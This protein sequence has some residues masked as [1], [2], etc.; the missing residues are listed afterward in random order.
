MP[1]GISPFDGAPPMRRLKLTTQLT[2][3]TGAKL[4]SGHFNGT[5]APTSY[6]A[7]AELI[8]IILNPA[9]GFSSW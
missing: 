6:T 9:V 4:G 5:K 2:R 8:R 7:R 3:A 1:H